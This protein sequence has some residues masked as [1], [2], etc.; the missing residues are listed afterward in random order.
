MSGA[1]KST[2]LDA[3]EDMGWDCVD[4]LPAALLKSFVHGDGAGMPPGPAAVGMDVRS[5]GFDAAALPGSLKSIQGV[6]PEI[7]YLDCA[8]T[9]LMRRYNETRRLAPAGARPARRGRH[10]PGACTYGAA[11]GRR[12]QHHRHDRPYPARASRRTSP[13]IRRLQRPAGAY[14]CLIW[15]RARRFANCGFDVRHEIFG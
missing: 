5:R 2:V 15:I 11:P 12:R 3:L 6:R 9:E 8:G 4:N 14:D 7:L 1:G 13:A 10:S